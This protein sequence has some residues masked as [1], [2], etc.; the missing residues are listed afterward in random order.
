[1]RSL[2]AFRPGIIPMLLLLMRFQL[3]MD[4]WPRSEAASLSFSFPSP[5]LSI[6]LTC[7]IF[8]RSL[9]GVVV[10]SMFISSNRYFIRSHP[11]SVS[12]LV[13]LLAMISQ[14]AVSAKLA[15]ALW[16]ITSSPII[17]SPVLPFLRQVSM[18]WRVLLSFL[19]DR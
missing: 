6:M 1:K 19:F 14:H 3:L 18:P 8:S 5:F 13:M 15:F 16:A 7:G 9:N 4:G 2:L 10:A 17:V 11:L 12:G